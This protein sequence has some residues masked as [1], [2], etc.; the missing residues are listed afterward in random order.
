[1]VTVIVMIVTMGKQSQVGGGKEPA[2]F[3]KSLG[4]RQALLSLGRGARHRRDDWRGGGHATLPS[5]PPSSSPGSFSPEPSGWTGSSTGPGPAEFALFA[6]SSAGR[7]FCE[8]WE[9]CE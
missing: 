2:N 9:F 3:M 6:K 4:L 1:M 5:G 8:F 7:A